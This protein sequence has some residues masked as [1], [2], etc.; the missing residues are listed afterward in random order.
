M[1]RLA[2]RPLTA[3]APYP[4]DSKTSDGQKPDHAGSS[5]GPRPRHGLASGRRPTVGRMA[6][7]TEQ[8]P[9]CLGP[10]R[11]HHRTVGFQPCH[12]TDGRTGHR[13]YWCQDCRLEISVRVCRQKHRTALQNGLRF[14]DR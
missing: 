10:S 9:R 8:P 3:R 5:R 4:T 6:I 2:V 7:L 1:G 12:C 14:P 13:T 11:E